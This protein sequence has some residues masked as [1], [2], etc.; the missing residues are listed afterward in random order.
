[1]AQVT[2]PFGTRYHSSRQGANKANA[3]MRR[4]DYSLA[5]KQIHEV[6]PVKFGGNPT[7]LANKIPL[8]PS[9]HYSVT[10]WWNKV[11]RNI[12]KK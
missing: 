4:A 10:N 5:G 8:A 1:M 12:R 3:M 11:M 9:T 7:D 2:C 6:Q